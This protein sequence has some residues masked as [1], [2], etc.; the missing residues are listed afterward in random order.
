MASPGSKLHLKAGMKLI[1]L[2]APEEHAGIFRDAPSGCTV[3]TS[4]R[5]RADLVLL[6]A[7]SV[8]DLRARF[9]KVLALPG[10]DTPLWIAY[11]KL[12]GSIK[13]DLTRDKGWDIV[14]KAGLRPVT[15]I[16]LDETWSALRFRKAELVKKPSAR[17]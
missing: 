10:K 13:S 4:P 17:V 3:S 11:P 1:L 2:N 5:G 8:K 12:T 15:L 16:S 6:F 9:P 14:R 7:A